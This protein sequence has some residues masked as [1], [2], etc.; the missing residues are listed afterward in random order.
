MLFHRHHHYSKDVTP[1]AGFAFHP[2]DALLQGLPL[3]LAPFIFPEHIFVQLGLGFL[4][5][6]WV[7]LQYT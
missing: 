5:T 7:L 3:F 2:I 4:T 1:F 6:T